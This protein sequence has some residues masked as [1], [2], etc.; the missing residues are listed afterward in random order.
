MGDEAI[1]TRLA[2]D[3]SDYIG[4]RVSGSAIVRALLRFADE[5]GTVWAR[6]QI[7]TF[8]EQEMGTGVAWGT[9][10]KRKR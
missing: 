7:F 8:V 3:A 4:R 10:P 9:A 5:Q 6:E 1:L 2:G